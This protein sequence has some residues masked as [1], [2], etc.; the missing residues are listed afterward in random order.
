MVF[1]F[2]VL[3]NKIIMKVFFLNNIVSKIY[4]LRNVNI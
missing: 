2:S 3:V 1:G 4:K